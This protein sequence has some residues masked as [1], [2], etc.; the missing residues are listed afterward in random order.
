MTTTA[1]TPI[2]NDKYIAMMQR[3]IRALERR[4]IDDPSILAHVIMLAQ[5]LA[6][7]TN[8]VIAESS[9]A[10]ASDPH[11]APSAGELARMLGMSK[12]GASQRGIRGQRTIFERQMGMETMTQRERAARTRAENHART[13]LET[14][15]T[16]RDEAAARAAAQ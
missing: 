11:R 2:E 14:W 16:R 7:I 8:V 6:E 13:T 1:K 12:Q 3:M 15:L 9:A 4:A 5:Q 10:Y